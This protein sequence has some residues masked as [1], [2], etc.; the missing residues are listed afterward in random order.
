MK[1]FTHIR[2]QLMTA[3][4]LD[5]TEKRHTVSLEHLQHNQL[6]VQ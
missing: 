6:S 1:V 4:F 3:R 5:L 2:E